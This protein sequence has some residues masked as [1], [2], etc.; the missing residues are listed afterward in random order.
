MTELSVA[1]DFSRFPFGRYPDHGPHNGQRFR[2]EL[3]APRLEDGEV[4]VDLN[5]ARGL[6]PSFLEEAFGGLVRRGFEVSLLRR[7]LKIV[8]ETD[9]SRV[10]EAW[11]YIE[12]AARRSAS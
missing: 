8:C 7:R 5:G 12:N 10:E 11:A 1:R 4:V 9:P 6:A 3:L 2:E